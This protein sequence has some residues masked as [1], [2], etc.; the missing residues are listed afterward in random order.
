VDVEI[1]SI[2]GLMEVG[3]LEVLGERERERERGWE[4]RLN[5]RLFVDEGAKEIKLGF[6]SHCWAEC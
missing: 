5:T 1:E 6:G 4:R 3:L 2:N